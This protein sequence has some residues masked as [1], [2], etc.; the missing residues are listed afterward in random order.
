MALMCAAARECVSLRSP[1]VKRSNVIKNKAKGGSSPGNGGDDASRIGGVVLP[2]CSSWILIAT[3]G[4][5]S[6]QLSHTTSRKYWGAS[7]VRAPCLRCQQRDVH[8]GVLVA[9]SY[10]WKWR[11]ASHA[12]S[13]AAASPAVK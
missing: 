2:P 10:R 7:G 1:L 13:V 9:T 5:S 3:P 4:Y 8:R 12:C 6:R 11:Q